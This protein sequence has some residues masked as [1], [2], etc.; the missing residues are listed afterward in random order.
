[1]LN[2]RAL[3]AFSYL[4]P[5]LWLAFST[6]LRAAEGS[7]VPVTELIFEESEPGVEPYRSRM[8]LGESWLRLD[9]GS[10]DGDFILFDRKAREI[11][12]YNRDDRTEMVIPP[13]E[14]EP[15]DFELRYEQF[16]QPLEDAP[17]IA[18]NTPVEYRYRADGKLCR[19]SINAPGL[20]PEFTAVLKDYEQ[21]LAEQG[22]QTLA[23]MPADVRE[24]CYM[25]NNFLH[26]VDYY[27]GGFPLFV[28]ND[29]QRSRRLVGYRETEVPQ[30]LMQPLQGYR[31]YSPPPANPQQV[32]PGQATPGVLS[33]SNEGR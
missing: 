21:L 12:S 16:S 5:S 24:S 14:I 13:R 6:P 27:E 17:K 20:L 23:R 3:L 8:L 11:R 19:R 2:P 30:R 15:V 4:L 18:G 9:G 25:S 31:R 29:Q 10:D 26:P 1:M 7:P 33:I 28:I 32:Q 22:K